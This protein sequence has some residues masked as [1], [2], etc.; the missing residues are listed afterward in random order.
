[1]RHAMA[2]VDDSDENLIALSVAGDPSAFGRL[3]SRYEQRVYGMCV[4]SLGSSHHAEE[5]TQDIFLAVY[6]NLASFR[7]DA[8]FS[9]WLH[10]ITIN[11]CKNHRAYR[12]RRAWG[13]H[14][15]L[16]GTFDDG[17]ERELPSPEPGSDAPANRKEA[18]RLLDAALGRLDDEQ[19]TIILLRDMQDL[20]Y[21]E[22]AETLE[23][24]RGT[25]KSRL[26][27]ARSALAAVLA[28]HL[29]R[30]DVL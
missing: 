17:P 14:E 4:R 3:V 11:H 20:D 28:R 29:H 26:H 15:P 1:M 25:V 2:I 24:P 22:I 6:R 30:D 13:R 12:H 23:I 7:G 18:E 19:R 9:T 8:R 10:R 21:E 27:R 5:I 16:E